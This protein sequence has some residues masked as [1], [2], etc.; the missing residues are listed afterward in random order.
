MRRCG[1]LSH[2]KRKDDVFCEA[3]VCGRYLKL[4]D[5][6]NDMSVSAFVTGGYIKFMLLHDGK[7]DDTIRQFFNELYELYVKVCSFSFAIP[8]VCSPLN[9]RQVQMNPFYEPS[10]RITHPGFN[11]RVAALVKKYF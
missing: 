3:H 8:V 11:S 7:S 10:S 4:V 1:I 5:K 9:L 6:F 2:R